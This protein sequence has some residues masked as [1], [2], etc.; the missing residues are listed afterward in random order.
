MGLVEQVSSGETQVNAVTPGAE[1]QH[2][3]GDPAPPSGDLHQVAVIRPHRRGPGVIDIRRESSGGK[4]G[5]N[6]GSERYHSWQA[7][8]ND[9]TV[10][11][12]VNM[13]SHVVLQ[14]QQLAR[15]GEPKRA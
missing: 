4:G 14:A 13:T 12:I 7:L 15:R 1:A 5:A 6:S 11:D 9:A 10:E 8:Q 2:G 3:I